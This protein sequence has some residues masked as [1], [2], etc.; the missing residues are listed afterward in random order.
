MAAISSHYVFIFQFLLLNPSSITRCHVAG[1]S[2]LKIKRC[3]S[4]ER[5]KTRVLSIPSK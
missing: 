1:A 2:L 3:V 4:L 5:Y